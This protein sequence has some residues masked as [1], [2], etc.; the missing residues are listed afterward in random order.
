MPAFGSIA[1]DVDGS[2][3]VEDYRYDGDEQPP[4]WTVFDSEHRMLGTVDLPEGPEVHQIGSDFVL[5]VWRDEMDVEHV[6]LY[7]VLK[8]K[9]VVDSTIAEARLLSSLDAPHLLDALSERHLIG[10]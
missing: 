1:V 10:T 7:G 3:W 5:G 8:P 2:L 6:Q 9:T 4:R